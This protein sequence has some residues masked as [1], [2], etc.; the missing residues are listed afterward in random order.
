LVL[1]EDKKVFLTYMTEYQDH[2]R[3]G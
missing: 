2:P 3:C 1:E